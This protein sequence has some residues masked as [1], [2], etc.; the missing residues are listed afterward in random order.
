MEGFA[1]WYEVETSLYRIYTLAHRDPSIPTVPPYVP[2]SHRGNVSIELH[3]TNNTDRTINVFWVDYKGN[4]VPKGNI[5]RRNGVWTQTT[6]I[7]HPWVFEDADTST[8]YLYYVPYRA[9]PTIPAAPTIGSD[10]TIG[11]HKFALVSSSN[12]QEHPFHI[13]IQDVVM[14]Y[15]GI[16]QLCK[17]LDAIYWTLNHMSRTN[18]TGNNAAQTLLPDLD[19]LQLYLIN[20]LKHPG[21]VKY[22]QLRIASP[23]FRSIWASPLRGV[24]L[25]IGFVEVG[26]CAELGC[27]DQALSSERV[28]EVALLSYLLNEWKREET[29]IST[30]NEQLQQQIHQPNGA[31]DGFGRAGFGRAGTNN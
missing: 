12:N 30:L 9:I 17:P 25:A 14:P 15:P 11:L 2:H 29:E 13:G 4:Y 23:R 28:Q 24:L 18:V 31:I 8:P 7:D 1:H 22:R 21:C 19:T 20:V 27:H 6:W 10:E 26:P 16:T 5:P 3:V